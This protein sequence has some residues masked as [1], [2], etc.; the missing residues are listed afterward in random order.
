MLLGGGCLPF[1]HPEDLFAFRK[2]FGALQTSHAMTKM[3]ID[4]R[5]SFSKRPLKPGVD[6]FAR[7]HARRS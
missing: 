3:A 6:L 4:E 2:P 5:I 7:C 1:R